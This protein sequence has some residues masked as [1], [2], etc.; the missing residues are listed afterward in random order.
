MRRYK[1]RIKCKLCGP[2]DP[3]EKLS[4]NQSAEFRLTWIKGPTCSTKPTYQKLSHVEKEQGDVWEATRAEGGRWGPPT[5]RPTT[6]V[7]RVGPTPPTSS[8]CMEAS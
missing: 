7:G 4:T 8:L 5:R 2:Y 3:R 6:L 1:M